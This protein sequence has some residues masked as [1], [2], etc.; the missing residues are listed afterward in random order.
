[1]VFIQGY[2][3]F[4]PGSWDVGNFFT[5]YTMIFACA[6]FFLGWKLFK[7]TRFV[8]PLAADLVWDKPVIDAY[9]ETRGPPLGLWED[10]WVSFLA[11]V[12]IKK[13]DDRRRMSVARRRSS[14]PMVS[15]E[16]Q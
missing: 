7:R 8:H 16:K 9:E 10:M 14:V 12:R 11:M 6:A 15:G 2:Y 5:Y 1:V 4:L 3:V 13:W